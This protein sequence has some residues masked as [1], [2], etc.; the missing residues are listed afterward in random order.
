MIDNYSDVTIEKYLEIKAVIDGGYDE[1][2]T[3]VKLVSILT[4]MTE[5]EVGSLS[6]T[7]YQKMNQKLVF[8]TEMPAQKM[9]ATKYKLGKYDLETMLNVKDM[10]VSQYIDYQTFVKDVDRYMVEL[11]SIF[12]IPK[13]KKYNEGYDIIEVHKAIRE[14][15]SIMDAMSMAGFFLLSYQSLT[16]ATLSS[17][18]RRMKRMKRKMKS[19][20]EIAKMEEAIA[21]LERSGDGLHL[22]T[23]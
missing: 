7:D 21:N 1:D 15:L 10:T 19:Q 17:L 5:D 22:L 13:G 18:I 2:V 16:K 14:N 6:L 3:N 9:I 20:E 12:L 11:L 23:K 4:D 8:L